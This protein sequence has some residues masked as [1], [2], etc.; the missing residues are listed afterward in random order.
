M[1]PPPQKF[2]TGALVRGIPYASGYVQYPLIG[3]VICESERSNWWGGEYT[4]WYSI[5]AENGKIVEEL[6]KYIEEIN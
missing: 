2:V 6:E 5:L 1:T 3:I 4:R